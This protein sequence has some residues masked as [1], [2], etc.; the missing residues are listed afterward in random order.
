MAGLLL[1]AQMGVFYMM[2]FHREAPSQRVLAAFPETL[3]GW[4]MIQD[5]P[6]DKETAEALRADEILNRS[7]AETGAGN[8]VGLFVAFFQSPKA[9]LAPHSPKV[10]LPISGWIASKSDTFALRV[11]GRRD[12]VPVN[13]YLISRGDEEILVI[14]WYQTY[15]HIAASEYRAKLDLVLDSMWRRRSDEMFVRIA[16]P[17][18][19]GREDLAEEIASRYVQAA[20][21]PLRNGWVSPEH[22]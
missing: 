16:V 13:R 8:V 4:H 20:F 2:P 9:G 22:S 5:V 21:K 12:A 14:Y 19:K 6:I 7:Y 3:G 17:V 1:L 15:S 11:A 10:C 18:V